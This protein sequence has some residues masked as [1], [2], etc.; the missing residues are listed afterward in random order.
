MVFGRLCINENSTSAFNYWDDFSCPPTWL[1][2][3]SLYTFSKVF[4][5]I[6]LASLSVPT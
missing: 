1:P 6:T 4:E 3:H 5:I 2:P